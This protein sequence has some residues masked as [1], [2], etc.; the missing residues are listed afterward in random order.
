M[1]KPRDS[2]SRAFGLPRKGV[3]HPESMEV[4]LIRTSHWLWRWYRAENRPTYL[5][6]AIQA[7]VRVKMAYREPRKL[8]LERASKRMKERYRAKKG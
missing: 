3:S 5:S 7:M 8:M 1:V 6:D 2:D 4:L